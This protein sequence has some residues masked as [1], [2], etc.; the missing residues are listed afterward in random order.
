MINIPN[1]LIIFGAIAAAALVIPG[2]LGPLMFQD[3][4]AVRNA[5]NE[6][7]LNQGAAGLVAA[8]VGL[9]TG[10]VCVQAINSES[11]NCT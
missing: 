10:D 9:Q 7:S 11:E 8:N 3:A 5:G 1:K 6:Q 2:T 4:Q